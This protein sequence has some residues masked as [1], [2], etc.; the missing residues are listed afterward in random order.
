MKNIYLTI[1][2]ISAVTFSGV[3]A[4][5]LHPSQGGTGTNIV[6][7]NGQVLVAT[8]TNLYVP[9]NQSVLTAP[10]GLLT[11][12]TLASNVVDSSLTSL[13]TIVTGVWNATR[14][15]FA[16]LAQGSGL[17]VLGVAG[18]STADHASI[19][20]GTDDQVLR[21]SGTS[22]GFGAVNL[23][24]S[25]A[26]T[27]V[28]PLSFGGT[29]TTTANG[30]LNVLLP[31]Q[32]TNSG[33]FLT[34]N[35]IDA[36]WGTV[37]GGTASPAGSNTQVQF[38]N[39]GVFGADANFS[40]DNTNKKLQ[41]GSTTTTYIGT[42]LSTIETKDYSANNQRSIS[43]NNSNWDI[44]LGTV[45]GGT[46]EFFG[47]KES[48][49]I[50]ATSTDMVGDFP[51]WQA[52]VTKKTFDLNGLTIGDDVSGD[53]PSA[54][55][56]GDYTGLTGSININNVNS[57]AGNM[58]KIYG[59]RLDMTPTINT[60]N[61]VNS[62]KEIIG[63]IINLAPLG[64]SN[65]NIQGMQINVTGN[66]NSAVGIQS[67][68]ISN[69]GSCTATGIEAQASNSGFGGLAVGFKSLVNADGFDAYAFKGEGSA[70]SYLNG[71]LGVGS[72]SPSSA[73]SVKALNT[74]SNI[75]T[76]AST[77]NLVLFQVDKKGHIKAG[78]V[79]PTMGTCGTT[80]SVVG[81]DTRGVITVG[82]GISVT[83]C[84]LNFKETYTTAPVCVISTSSTGVTAKITS[85][86]TTVL[87]TGF[88]STLGGGKVYYQCLE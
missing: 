44:N 83:S 16:Y 20:A 88:S 2:I 86:S 25:N 58:L 30:A 85:I 63:H 45:N 73:L 29:G 53:S 50:T 76:V 74:T 77:T 37:S 3:S 87:M 81:N 60:I 75:F 48:V 33:K 15:A 70:P 26:V 39:S 17:S 69:C 55:I 79:T 52:G 9:V 35:G 24:S 6:P 82:S 51:S 7:S 32:I 27:G 62:S 5:T 57:A 42:K 36:S 18:N 28:L 56:Y 41:L 4:A 49:K 31:S 65:T 13:G 8:T 10:A 68:G 19:V 40:W 64:L 54:T 14:L 59:S 47:R 21:R 84:A 66:S 1:G 23:A 34:T 72:S 71:A 43:L 38:N 12:T 22:L 78:G 61:D 67:V 11:G 46:G 80:P